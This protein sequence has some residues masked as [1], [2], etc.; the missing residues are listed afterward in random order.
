M[1]LF[2]SP[3]FVC[4]CKR[5]LRGVFAAPNFRNRASKNAGKRENIFSALSGA[6]LGDEE[7]EED[8]GGAHPRPPPPRDDLRL[9]AKYA[10]MYDKYSLQFTLCY[11]IDKSLLLRI[12][13]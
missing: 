4:F 12:R 7:E 6:D 5:Y 11:Y 10:D 8:V 1:F 13:F 9:S 3:S 2:S